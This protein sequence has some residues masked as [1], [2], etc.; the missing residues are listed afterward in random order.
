MVKATEN[1]ALSAKDGS[2]QCTLID[3]KAF[4]SGSCEGRGCGEGKAEWGVVLTVTLLL[5]S[6]I[7]ASLF[8]S[9]CPISLISHLPLSCQLLCGL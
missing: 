7:S 5:V 9:V 8:P 6:N 2:R 4:H 1:K 3:R